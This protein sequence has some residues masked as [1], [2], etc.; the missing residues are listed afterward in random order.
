R[1]LIVSY[2][3][4]DSATLDALLSRSAFGVINFWGGEPARTIVAQ[5]VAENKHRPRLYVNGPLTGVALIDAEAADDDAADGLAMNM[6]LYDQ[7]L[8]S[9]P[10]LALFVGEHAQSLEF[11]KKVA[12]FLDE[13][14]KDMPLELTESSL[15]TLQNGRRM[16]QMRGSTV[17]AGRSPRN[18][19]TLA[20]SN[21]R[22]NMDEVA[23]QYRALSIHGR[24]R[25]LEIITVP[26]LDKAV[27]IINALPS[28]QA[29]AGIDKVQTIGLAAPIDKE[30]DYLDALSRTGVYRTVPV[31]DMFMRSA[32][33]PYDGQA[34]ASLF[35]YITY[36][37][38]R[39]L[40][41]EDV[42]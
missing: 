20:V 1:G 12:A 19:W 10:T 4:H 22:S 21:G 38:G 2:L 36:R 25:F 32:V 6:V 17:M 40:R 18:T 16:L 31:G 15:F 27:E 28:N 39:N 30:N 7:Q 34:L 23:A 35:T 37:R 41:L 24:R 13:E 33:E 11:A 5:K 9:S 29:F 14:G 26:G 3:S 8:C 42:L